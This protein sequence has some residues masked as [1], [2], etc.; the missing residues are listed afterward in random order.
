[1]EQV[2]DIYFCFKKFALNLDL[3]D[4]VKTKPDSE[5][6]QLE[7]NPQTQKKQPF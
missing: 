5:K 2:N 6:D 4:E 1:M 7:Q 3:H